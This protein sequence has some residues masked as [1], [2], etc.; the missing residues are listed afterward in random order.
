MRSE[1]ENHPDNACRFTYTTSLLLKST[2]IP[3]NSTF[4]YAQ[5]TTGPFFSH[6][7]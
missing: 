5:S 2:Q 4:N 6:A 3:S 1:I 7:P